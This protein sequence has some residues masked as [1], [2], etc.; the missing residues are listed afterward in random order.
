MPQYKIK[1]VD[2]PHFDEEWIVSKSWME[3]AEDE[4]VHLIE[5]LCRKNNLPVRR[6]YIRELVGGRDGVSIKLLSNAEIM[7]RANAP[8]LPLVWDAT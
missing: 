8:Q 2:K 1:F 7:E 6:N 5:E 4:A 3:M